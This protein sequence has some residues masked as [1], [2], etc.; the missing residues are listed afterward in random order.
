MLT[1]K[2][3]R[4]VAFLLFALGAVVYALGFIASSFGHA[5]NPITLCGLGIQFVGVVLMATDMFA[6]WCGRFGFGRRLAKRK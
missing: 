5:K 4:R 1:F 2:K 3:Q 6:T